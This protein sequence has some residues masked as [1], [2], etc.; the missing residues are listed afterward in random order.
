MTG[1]GCFFKAHHGSHQ[2]IKGPPSGN[3]RSTEKQKHV[4]NANLGLKGRD[5]GCPT[6]SVLGEPETRYPG[7]KPIKMSQCW[8]TL[9]ADGSCCLRIPTHMRCRRRAFQDCQGFTMGLLG[10]ELKAGKGRTLDD[11]VRKKCGKNRGIR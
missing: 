7:V 8:T 6:R 11:L 5:K 10:E 4:R 2:P 1:G 3:Q 9:W